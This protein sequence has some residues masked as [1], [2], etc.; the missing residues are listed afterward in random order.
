MTIAVP[1]DRAE[2][3][4]SVDRLVRRAIREWTNQLMDVSGYGDASRRRR[5]PEAVVAPWRFLPLDT[6]VRARPVG[7]LLCASS[8]S[9][10][11]AR[12]A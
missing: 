2:E 5:R 12:R 4:E 8:R 10:S 7:L 6:S 1:E 11:A 9:T 3:P